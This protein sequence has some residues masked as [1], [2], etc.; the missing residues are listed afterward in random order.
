M[1]FLSSLKDID[2]YFVKKLK[3]SRKEGFIDSL[4]FVGIGSLLAYGVH[5][6]SGLLSF[7]LCVFTLMSAGLTLAGT[8]FTLYALF[9]HLNDFDLDIDGELSKNRLNM[10]YSRKEE[11]HLIFNTILSNALYNL[12]QCKTT[13]EITKI[14]KSI[15]E[16]QD[17]FIYNETIYSNNEYEKLPL[18]IKENLQEN[19]A[20]FKKQLTESLL[21]IHKNKLVKNNEF[22]NIFNENQTEKLTLIKDYALAQINGKCIEEIEKEALNKI[23][24]KNNSFHSEVKL[25]NKKLSL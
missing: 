7:V 6:F 3:K 1:K 24:L 19:E 23:K 8:I 5:C 25:H 15:D 4:I 10:N 2:Y 20:I 13:E 11:Y 18:K 16:I 12:N 21:N 22:K 9:G 14:V 17:K